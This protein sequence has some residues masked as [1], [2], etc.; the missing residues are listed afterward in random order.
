MT[1]AQ[2]PGQGIVFWPV[3]FGDSTTIVI[4][5]RHVVQVD[6]HDMV[7][8]GEDGAV[9]TPVIDRL[10]ESLPEGSDGRPYL[11]AFALTHADKDHVLGFR[12]LL[13]RVII[14]EIWA[15]PRLWREQAEAE[16]GLCPDAEA[17]HEEAARRVA[18][19][20]KAAAAGREPASGDRI[21]VIGY[22]VAREDHE[23]SEL[24]AEYMSRPGDA[25]SR[26]DGE[27]LG[28]RFEVFIHAP[29]KDDCAA[30]RNATS[31]AMQVTLKDDS[32]SEGHALLLGDLA[33]ETIEKIFS[34][35]EHHGRPER[36]A[37]EALLAPHHCSKRVMYVSEDGTDVLKRDILDAMSRHAADGAVIVV[38]SSTFRSEDEPGDN[39]PHIMAR[40]RY[41]ELADEVV[42][43][44]EHGGAGSPQPVV[45]TVGPGGLA[46]VH[47]VETEEG[48]DLG[49]AAAAVGLGLAIGGLLGLLIDRWAASRSGRPAGQASPTVPRGLDRVR[50]AVRAARGEDAAPT[51]PVGFG[52]P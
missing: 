47:P 15:T 33:Y 27:E 35:S 19:V 50:L 43:T 37:W 4:D 49:K 30:E 40:R 17:F 3:G 28:D 6:I 42:V 12:D 44:A 18:A 20:R 39:P 41:E 2:L 23:Y 29:F 36:L 51:Q 32:G 52:R 10:V 45:F 9:V 38:S 8:A 14:G 24:P 25:V 48:G 1:N 46:L 22:D 31:L 11:A 13:E 21:R 7:S 5:D 16:G 34:Y 26:L